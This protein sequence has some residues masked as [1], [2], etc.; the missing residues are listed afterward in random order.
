[1]GDISDK[2]LQGVQG[3]I[4]MAPDA[5]VR[6]LLLALSAD[7]GLDEGLARVQRLVETEAADRQARNLAFA[8]IAPLCSAPAPFK[9][10]VFPPRTLGLLWKA[11]KETAPD[12]IQAAKAR[13]DN[14]RGEEDGAEAL[15]AVCMAAA[16]GL[17]SGAPQ[18]VLAAAAA[19]AGAGRD[20][21][22]ACLDIA[23]VTR[24][25]LTQMPEWLGR[26]TSEKTAKLRLAYGDSVNINSEAGP[27]F[28]EMLAAHL[29]EPWLI[30]RVIS[31]AMDKPSDTYMAASELRAFGERVLAH[32]D[33]LVA[34]VVAFS[35]ASG[36][37]GAHAV[38]QAVH[39][40]VVEITEMEI[41]M[42]LSAGGVWGKRVAAQKKL[43]ATT[44]E[45]RLKACDKV[46][47]QALPTKTVRIG[48]KSVRSVPVLA[49]EPDP[50]L[51]ENAGTLLTFLGEVRS[52]A[53]DGGF[54]SART[55]VLEGVDE[56]LDAYIE[57]L[58]EE[59]RAD[60]GVD[61]ARAQAY[62]DI[63][64]D[65]CGLTRD[66]KAAQIIRRRAAAARAA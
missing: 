56:W 59:I 30:L 17:R 9:G 36:R 16:D 42:N 21:L 38:A 44:I 15:D 23:A 4:E 24:A 61:Q 22:I 19:D 48:P 57:E 66:D 63:A 55:K 28:F 5:A 8:P 58:L 37:A 32:I 39:Q 51:V 12:E 50:T 43:L 52:S 3:L 11:L 29:S 54:A 33:Q 14:W 65:F 47:A 41:S 60:E 25:A 26:M 6:S 20:A 35:A 62:L 49:A 1:M 10:L 13:A 45:A 2:K 7:S 34:D 27:L 53:P 31:G 18:F 46:L 64:A 40:A